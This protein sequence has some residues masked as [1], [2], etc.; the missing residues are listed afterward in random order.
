VSRKS[1]TLTEEQKKQVR[2]NPPFMLNSF[3]VAA[4]TNKHVKLVREWMN[5]PDFPLLR[6]PAKNSEMHV[7]R[8]ELVNWMTKRNKKAEVTA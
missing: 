5:E 1:K 8:D 6:G 4:L 3:E 7:L 2:L